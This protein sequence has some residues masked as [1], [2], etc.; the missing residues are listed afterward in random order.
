MNSLQKSLCPVVICPYFCSF[1]FKRFG[2]GLLHGFRSMRR[3]VRW[4]HCRRTA[5]LLRDPWHHKILQLQTQTLCNTNEY[6]MIGPVL[7]ALLVKEL[8]QLSSD[9]KAFAFKKKNYSAQTKLQTHFL[10]DTRQISKRLSLLQWD[11]QIQ[12]SF[13]PQT[14]PEST[15]SIHA[16]RPGLQTFAAWCCTVTSH[17]SIHVCVHIY[18]YIYMFHICTY[19]HTCVYI[20][21]YIYVYDSCYVMSCRITHA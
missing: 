21:I 5:F 11:K 19:V 2:G 18:I 8:K 16:I 4:L 15:H 9:L 14:R 12:S 20:Y 13:K 10:Q 1:E 17:C 3:V 7:R 6:C